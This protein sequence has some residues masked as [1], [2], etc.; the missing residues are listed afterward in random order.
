M[1]YFSRLTDIV[2][3]N[4]SEI[5]ANEEDPKAAIEQIVYEIQEGVVGAERSLKTARN[6]VE[7]LELE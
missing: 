1:S 7:K 6:H 5:L 4:L 2:T 3:C